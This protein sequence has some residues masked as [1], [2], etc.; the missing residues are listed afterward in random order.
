MV[1]EKKFE[2]LD[3]S[4]AS[5]T[6]TIDAASIEKE[7][8]EK[9]KKYA[10][11]I[12]MPGFRKG[13][14]PAA[15]LEKKIG[16]QVREE[17]TFDLMEKNLQETIKTLDKKEQPLYYCV[18]VLQDE[19]TLLPFKKDQDVTFTVKYDVNPVFDLPQYKGLEVE[20]E[21]RKVTDEDVERKIE[22]LREQ[23]ALIV[24]KS[25]PAELSDIATISYSVTDSDGTELE[26]YSRD[27]FSL[28][29]GKTYN[30]F[31][32]DDD[33]VGMSTGEEKDAE[34]TYGE[35]DAPS[36]DLTNK[37]VKIHITL[38]KLKK[39]ELPD[40]DDDFA[41]DVKDEYK[42]VE[43]L[44]KGV[45]ADLEKENETYEENAKK[46][47]VVKKLMDAVDI[48]IPASMVE[49]ISDNKWNALVNQIGGE[50]NMQSY[51][52]TYEQS[53]DD[54]TASWKE[55]SLVD[56]KREVI[57]TAIVEKEN[58]EASDDDIKKL[59]G[60]NFDSLDEQ[61]KENYRQYLAEE[62]KYQKVFPF[63]LEN[64]TFKAVEEKKEEAKEE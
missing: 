5:L 54:I 31:K 51:L 56:A 49:A 12:E 43:D 26:D 41:Q 7:Y 57:L 55:E 44:K 29:L 53:K 18:P 2:F 48:A 47:A 46:Y 64:N 15:I 4:Q 50:K 35:E 30:M 36:S 16:D 10:S 58:I 19:E 28:T 8:S 22:T 38:T 60:E 37:S 61:T 45:R 34:R 13:H 33:I 17:V 27:D 62:A 42:T 40:I 21:S 11:T 9:I 1:T 24:N 6:L 20:Y 39:R 3:N 59:A 52:K 63:L 14:V 32:L 25:T 23:S